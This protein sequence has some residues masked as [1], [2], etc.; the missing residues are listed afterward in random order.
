VATPA[1]VSAFYDWL[2]CLAIEQSAAGVAYPPL[3]LDLLHNSDTLD[4]QQG[5]K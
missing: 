1:A 4:L 5:G 3:L 2:V